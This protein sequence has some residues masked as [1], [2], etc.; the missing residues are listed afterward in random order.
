[1]GDE[2]KLE[3]QRV[4][5]KMLFQTPDEAAIHA[6]NKITEPNFEM[7]GVVYKDKHGFYSAS[8]PQG[9]Q[10]QSKFKAEVRIP[11]SA[12][13][14]GIYHTHPGVESTN[15]QFSP[16]DIKVANEMKMASYIRALENGKIKK[17]EPGKTSVKSSGTGLSKGKLSD[18]DL[19]YQRNIE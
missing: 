13:P 19:I 18:G 2:E 3:Y 8:D 5:A 17:Y 14:Y 9:D 10:R 15:E 4:L 7:G 12:T 16:D 1:M 6:L 11:K